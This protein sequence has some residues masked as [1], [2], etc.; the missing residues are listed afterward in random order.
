MFKEHCRTS[1]EIPR[2]T[3]RNPQ[4]EVPHLL[5][6]LGEAIHPV[7]SG[8]SW[9]NPKGM[10]KERYRNSMEIPRNTLRNPSTYLGC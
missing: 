9:W 2:K 4:G 7:L 10:F 1:M 3:L 6:M 8:G 5:G